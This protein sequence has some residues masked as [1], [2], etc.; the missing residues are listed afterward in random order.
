MKIN[1][2][3]NVKSFIF[4]NKALFYFQVSDVYFNRHV[5]LGHISLWLYVFL[6]FS[7]FCKGTF[8]TSFFKL[9]FTNGYCSE[10]IPKQP[11]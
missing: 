5:Y 7:G 6:D 9:Y 2:F 8:E 3:Y 11:A 1:A 4:K 10:V